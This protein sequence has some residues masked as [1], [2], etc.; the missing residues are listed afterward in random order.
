MK[1]CA[2]CKHVYGDGGRMLCRLAKKEGR[3]PTTG[4]GDWCAAWKKGGINT[5]VK[6]I[7]SSVVYPET[8]TRVTLIYWPEAGRVRIGFSPKGSDT[9]E[10][11]RNVEDY[12]I[13]DPAVLEP[14]EYHL[15]APMKKTVAAMRAR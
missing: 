15:G 7:V 10:W 14:L 8:L 11:E 12:S 4:P 6:K 1:T 5:H 3:D 2:N 13:T 9:A